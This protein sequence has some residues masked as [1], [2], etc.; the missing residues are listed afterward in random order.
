MASVFLSYVRE[1]ADKARAIAAILERGGHSVWWDRQ[2]KGGAQ[3]SSE[4]EAALDAA[5][6]VVVLW[7]ARSVQSAWV[8]D[9][10]AAG[11]DSGR[12]VPVRLDGTPPPLGFRQ[13]QSID[14]S[15]WNGR[16][17]APQI[18][19]LQEAL[20]SDRPVDVM[21]GRQRTPRK[22]HFTR[23]ILIGGGSLLAIA[24]AGALAWELWPA[25]SSGAPTFAIIPVDS[26]P[27]ATQ[28]AAGVATR[29]AG[30]SDPSGSDFHIA[31]AAAETA[32]DNYA[33]KVTPS[34][35]DR[36]GSTLTLV[37]TDNAII[38]SSTID[39]P[40][41]AAPDRAQATAIMA[42]RA[43]SCTA[44][45]LSH[46][47]DK[48]DQATLKL[49]VRGCTQ[50]DGAYGTN[51]PNTALSKTFQE[52]IASAP[53]IGPAWSK[54]FALETED[55]S[56]P[57]PSRDKLIQKVRR[58]LD[59]ARQ[60]GI[61]VPEAYAVQANL[62]SPADFIGVFKV[63]DEGI[64][65]H[66]DSAFLF[67]QRGERYSFVGRMNEAVGDTGRAVQLDP[68]SPANQQ[69]F[70]SELAYAG[71]QAAAYEQLRKAERLWPNSLTVAMAR[72][73]MDLRFGDPREAQALY[74]KYAVEAGNPASAAFIQAR[75]NPTPANIEAALEAERKINRQYPPFVASLIQALGYFGRK[76]EAIDLLVNYPGGEY[77]DWI[78]FN[79]EVL[80]RPMMRD[81]WRDPRS[82][83][84]AAHVGLLHYWKTS[85]HWPDFCFDPTL[86]YDC[87]KEA[88]KYP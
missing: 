40:Q 41:G 44:D 28:F 75:I 62:L 14:L 10:A 19:D 31:D 83:A 5:E 26:S 29:V 23:P 81:V 52:V 1:D 70:A 49:Y 24:A 48:I 67:R 15:H 9:E 66:P 8:R 88:A 37:S 17:N 61:D 54:L 58:Q 39:M 59:R 38:W 55:V 16:S 43:L 21:P 30:L 12:L 80:F 73:R 46:H 4:I 45:A 27:A 65:K 35:S 79:A 86:P 72:Y 85:G 68:L 51:D 50:Y 69:S 56:Q 60:L 84:G 78:G 87:K 32:R 13:F 3:Y 63:F 33:L 34:S 64:A 82:M 47:R 57:D 22:L 7:S 11:R 42:Q 74:Q 36:P 18:K 6:K 53:H 25:A 77:A 2:I 76:D 20:A 71:N